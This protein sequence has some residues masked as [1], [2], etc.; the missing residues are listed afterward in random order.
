M[1]REAT[2][3][4][5]IIDDST[6]GMLGSLVPVDAIYYDQVTDPDAEYNAKVLEEY[7]NIVDLDNDGTILSWNNVPFRY[8]FQINGVTVSVNDYPA[9]TGATIMKRANLVVLRNW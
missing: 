5:F 1:I 9:G 7:R 4:D 8:E 6:S 2:T 3:V